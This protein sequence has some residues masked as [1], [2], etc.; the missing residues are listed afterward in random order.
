MKNSISLF[1]YY[2]FTHIILMLVVLALIP[3]SSQAE[4]HEFDMTIEDTRIV[5]VG[6]RD[7]H[8][9][10]YN[11]QVPAPL[12]HVKEGDEVTVNLTNM[13]TLPHTIHWHGML[14]RGTWQSDGVPHST[15]HAVEPGETYTYKF[16]AEP[17]GTMWY[18]CHVNVNEHVTMRGMWGPLIVE[19]K[20]PLPIEKKVTKDY[21]LMLSD[22]ASSWANKP[23]EGGI[24]GDVFDYYTI[25][26]KSFPETQPI[27]VKK[28]DVIRLRLFG[29]GDLVHSIH[30]H[31][32]ISQIVFKDG[33][34]LPNPI[35]ADTVLVGPGERYD[36]IIEMDNPGLWMIHDHVDTH[37]TNG[38][39]VDGGIMTTIEYEEVGLNH[40]FYVWK[41]KKFVPDFYY[42]ESMKK[43][44]GM[45]NSTVF[46]GE[47]IED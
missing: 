4:K 45:H 26:A 16:K 35:K 6:N 10:A 36:V 34:P 28:G 9:F 42:E 17:S 39:K 1:S 18:H 7:F 31:G 27:R 3:L 22:W 41:N 21:I 24:P 25:N 14:Q 13:T 30:T 23:G 29:S 46:K 33:F 12:L 47:L 32:H 40:D 44:F 15:Q 37:T 11:G 20:D 5:L 38:N 2:R 19:P 43:G 8:T